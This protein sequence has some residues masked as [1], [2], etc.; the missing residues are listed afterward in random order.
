MN[1]LLFL[2]VRVLE[3]AT[4]DPVVS[5]LSR[6]LSHARSAQKSAPIIVRIVETPH[7]PTGLAEVL[8]GALGL[9]GVL[10]LLA[11]AV[12]LAFGGILFYFR[13]RRPLG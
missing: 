10:V 5:G 7:D 8:V 12:G 13:S 3:R 9:T 1:L 11:L 4:R 6:T 2:A